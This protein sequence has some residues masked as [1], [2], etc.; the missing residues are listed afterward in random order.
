M[1][2]SDHRLAARE[3]LAGN[4][5]NAVLVALVAA[6][7]GGSIASGSFNFQ[8]NEEITKA[9]PEILKPVLAIWIGIASV[10]GWLQ[11]IVGGTIELGHCR[12][13]LKLHDRQ[14]ANIRDLFSQFSRLLQGFL[15]RLLTTIFIVLWTLLFVIPGIVATFRYAMAPFILYEHPEMSAMDA[16]RASKKMMDGHKWELFC[17][18]ISFI[19]WAI[20]SVLTCGIGFLFLNPYMSQAYASFYR[21]LQA[22]TASVESGNPYTEI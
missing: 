3:A 10:L 21:N 6:I 12:Y 11:F 1:K 14:E 7:L 2:A 15:L 5:V 4:W 20:L 18:N 17:L 16:I 13:V 9:L 19:G 22:Q 8:V